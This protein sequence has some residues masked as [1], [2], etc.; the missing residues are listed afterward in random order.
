VLEAADNKNKL[1][2]CE[3][4]ILK[5]LT[6]SKDILGDAKA[7]EIL[8]NAKKLSDEIEKKQEIAEKTEKEIDEAR[9]GYKPCAIRT[10]G[11][12][13]CITDLANIDP[14]YQYSLPFFISLFTNAI[15]SSEP[16]E[17]LSERLQFLN[18]EFLI[19]L[20]RNI[21]RSLFEKDKLIFSFLLCIKLLQ[22]AE[23]VDQAEFMYLL[24]G[25]VQI[26]ENEEKSPAEWLTEKS[27]GEVIRCSALPSFKGVLLNDF[28][29]NIE[30]FQQLFDSQSPDAFEY[31]PELAQKYN[32]FQ[33]MLIL[34]CLRGDKIV[35]AMQTFV[36]EKLG[37]QFIKPPPFDLNLIYKDSSNTTPLIF[38]LSPGSDPKSALDKYAE[39]RK[40]EI[41]GV[42]LGQGQGP[43]AEKMIKEALETGGWV[44]LQNCH[45]AVTWMSSL[46]KICEDIASDP[47]AASREFRLWLT[48]YPSKDF[49]VSIL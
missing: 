32:S 16:S 29:D 20:Y 25:G 49:P 41:Q 21:C 36:I 26:G 14:M 7:I 48:S 27:W 46:E 17:D 3:D 19:S 35:P 12:F 22:M 31:P 28:K 1:E 42:S 45:L 15:T 5:T 23:E 11:L 30:T 38:V 47:K 40:K 6:K 33:R 44:V 10:A 18:A 9:I 24:T 39:S 34:R 43:K 8:S 2:E 4:S 37:E 13:F